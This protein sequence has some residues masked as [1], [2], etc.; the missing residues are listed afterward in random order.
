[1]KQELGEKLRWRSDAARERFRLDQAL[2]KHLRPPTWTG[3]VQQRDWDGLRAAAKQI[4]Q[5]RRAS[6]ADIETMKFLANPAWD[7]GVP[8]DSWKVQTLKIECLVALVAAG[9]GRDPFV[10]NRLESLA[11]DY[12]AEPH[13]FNVSPVGL[14]TLVAMNDGAAI[15]TLRLALEKP[16]CWSIRL[17]C[18]YGLPE[19]QH[20]G[21]HSLI[22][23]F[24]EWMDRATEP[25]GPHFDWKAW[26]LFMSALTVDGLLRLSGH[27]MLHLTAP[28]ADNSPLIDWASERGLDNWLMGEAKWL[29]QR[30]L[31]GDETP[32]RNRLVER[33]VPGAVEFCTERVTKADHEGNAHYD[34]D[35]LLRLHPRP[36]SK[37]ALNACAEIAR[38][39]C[40]TERY[41]QRVKALQLLT[42]GVDLGNYPKAK[43]V[44]LILD[45][46]RSE[47]D[48]DVRVAAIDL[49]P[50]TGT[51][52]VQEVLA[53]ALTHESSRIREAALRAA[54][55]VE[56]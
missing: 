20:D 43:A 24:R 50:W 29:R 15:P 31:W 26:K 36:L 25:A 1:V 55:A 48:P 46:A 37:A 18:L 9:S 33:A 3:L 30:G 28:M 5:R 49:I 6:D 27:E 8:I 53:E 56:R 35:S 19:S 44:D 54:P 47:Q 12:L 34:V 39:R 23:E 2:S 45:L 32:L 51:K 7:P 13:G 52:N 38:M 42:E 10:L 17:A 16:S 14:L 22:E 21:N 11:V 41:Q 40:H 4:A